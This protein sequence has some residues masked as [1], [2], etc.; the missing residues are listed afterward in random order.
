VATILVLFGGVPEAD[1]AMK[2]GGADLLATLEPIL[3]CCVKGK[4][5]PMPDFHAPITGNS[6]AIF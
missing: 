2:N 4:L 3:T 5:S 1:D 6:Q